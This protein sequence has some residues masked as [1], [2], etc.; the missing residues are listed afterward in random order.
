MK[1]LWCVN[2]IL[3]DLAREIGAPYSPFEG[4][5]VSLSEG[6]ANAEGI[7]LAVATIYSGSEIKRV[8]IKNITYYLIPGGH[9]AKLI[10]GTARLK[11]YWQEVEKDFNP[12]L[13][14]LHGT[15]YAHGLALIE[16]CPNVPA[17]VSI[18][19]LLG[20]I[21]KHYYAGME[22]SD[23]FLRPSLRD[24]IRLD[25][26]WN[27]RR[28]FKKRA[29]F[30]REILN[31]VSHVIGRTTWDYANT[32]AINPKLVY[33]HCDES[34]R[35]LFYQ[36][37]WNIASIERHVIFTTQAGYPIKGLHILLKS[38]AL[39][40]PDYPGIKIYI[41]GGSL[42][43]NSV[44]EQLKI[45]GYAL[46]I[47]RLIKKFG[48]QDNV[49]FTGML[50]AEGMTGKLLK[51]HVFV[52]PS[53]IENSPNSLAEA[54]LLGVPCIGAYTGGIPDMLDGGQSGQLYH[55][56]EE[57]M[58]ANCI[59]RILESDEL[60]LKYSNAGRESAH[61]RHNRQKINETM[62]GI[63]RNILNG[64]SIRIKHEKTQSV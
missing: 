53:A 11:G 35:D 57:A 48:L 62:A 25:P 26:L 46:Y 7:K 63:Y 20:V 2:I 4:W 51:S 17:V 18:Q 40:K 50:D 36:K 44:M 9:K 28:T 58:L 56:M 34:L 5:I 1:V 29:V 23:V 33:H 3:P 64:E 12:N 24:I 6:L 27:W 10:R 37:N 38:V 19:G 55:F 14:H 45:P 13:L 21:E 61:R 16:A 8:D 22:F 49:V 52:I 54:M 59:R 47:K 60:A 42:L 39:L 30:E 32:W 41:A 31:K 15:E 43:G